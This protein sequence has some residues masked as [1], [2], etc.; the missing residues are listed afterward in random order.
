VRDRTMRRECR[1]GGGLSATCLDAS[2]AHFIR[3]QDQRGFRP[4]SLHVGTSL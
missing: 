1:G 3:G 2:T 4:T